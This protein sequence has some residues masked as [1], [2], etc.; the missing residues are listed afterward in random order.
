MTNLGDETRASFIIISEILSGEQIGDRLGIRPN[1][2]V[3]KGTPTGQSLVAQHPVNMAIFPSG[4]DIGEE[5]QTHI[6]ALVSFCEQRK[7][8]I[9]ELLKDCRM[10]IHCSYTVE[11][12]GGWQ[13]SPDLCQ[14]MASLLI[15]FVFNVE[16][17]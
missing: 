17:K 2:I 1:K 8:A 13:L 11:A 3:S 14:R 9:M 16:R 7:D 10:T 6:E 4:L 15:E 5:L 12:Q